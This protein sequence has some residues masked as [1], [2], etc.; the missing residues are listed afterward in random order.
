LVFASFSSSAFS[1]G[2]SPAPDRPPPSPGSDETLHVRVLTKTEHLRFIDSLPSVSFLQCPSWANVKTEWDSESLGWVDGSNQLVGS[3]LVLYRHLPKIRRGL[4][5][6]PEGPVIDW[7]DGNLSRWLHPLLDHLRSRGAFAAKIGPPLALRKWA[8]HTLKR[9]IADGRAKRLDDVPADFVD[10]RAGSVVRQLR[11]MAWQRGGHGTASLDVQPR[12]VF[13]VPL[14]GRSLEE[15]WRGFN[16]Q[17]R[18]NIRKAEKHGV[19]T[20]VG[21]YDDLPVFFELLKE[22]QKRDGF[23]L[24]RS[25]TYFQRQYKVLTAEDPNRMR[26]YLAR[27]RGEV[28]AAHTMITVGDRVWYQAGASASHTREVRPSHALQWQMIRDAHVLGASVYDMRGIKDTLERDAR[29][30][31]LLQWKLGTGGQTVQYVG[32]WEFALNRPL[33]SAYKLYMRWRRLS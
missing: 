5:Y 27:Y 15:V 19:E 12:Y 10:E 4:A 30:F 26:L 13:E 22:T 33:Y 32:E 6:I 11:S 20:V 18:R 16:Q 23:D 29:P 9:A 17:W 1:Y 31:G 3:A 8:A 14:A 25:L 2:E 7:S 21:G 24:G 28:L